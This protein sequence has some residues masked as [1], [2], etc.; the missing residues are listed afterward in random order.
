MA[1]NAQRD[2]SRFDAGRCPVQPRNRPLRPTLPALHRDFRTGIRR[3]AQCCVDSHHQRDGGGDRGPGAC[4]RRRSDSAPGPLPLL[5]SC[6]PHRTGGTPPPP[7][8]LRGPWPSH[9]RWLAVLWARPGRSLPARCGI[10]RSHPQGREA[11]GSAGAE[12]EQVRTGGQPQDRQGA[13]P[14]NSRQTGCHRRRGHRM[15]AKMKRRDFITLLGAASM[16]PLA[17]RAQQPA[18]PVIGFLAPGSLDAYPLYL[19]AFR[20][21]LNELGFVEGQNLA[22]EY[23]WAEGQYDR[24]PGLAADLVRRRVAVIAVPGSP[25]GALAAKAATST[26]AI[27]FSVGEDPVKLGLVSS[28]GQP[29]GNATGINFF[30]GELAAKRLALLHEL[31]PGAARLAVLVNPSDPIRTEAVLR[32]VQAAAGALGLQIQVFNARTSREIDADFAM[33]AHE[34]VDAVFVGPDP[35]FNTRRVQLANLAARYLMPATYAVRE[36]A[37]AGGLMSYGT[38]LG[39][40]FRQVGVYTGRILKGAKPSDLPVVQ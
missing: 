3:D 13:W 38:S 28:L 35:F 22:I 30:T 33:L 21:G 37:D 40:M 36:Y 12:P 25:P 4:A 24:L 10:R 14:P 19:A 16:W 32:E 2:R 8:H 23:R 7:G 11:S 29:E 20:K 6:A 1:G 17:A 5:Q 15:T 18:M 34:R 39:D 27:V 31:V 9:R 26:L